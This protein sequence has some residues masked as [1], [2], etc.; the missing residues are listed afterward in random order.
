MA[1]EKSKPYFKKAIDECRAKYEK[2]R[3]KYGDSWKTID[4][5]TLWGNLDLELRE[6]EEASKSNKAV[7][8][9]L[10]DV[11]NLCLMLLERTE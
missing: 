2:K 7:R 3:N 6:L 5:D 10:V 1:T 11:A 9:E 4:I 8:D